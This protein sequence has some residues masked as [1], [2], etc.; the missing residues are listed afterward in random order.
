MTEKKHW[1]ITL[2]E[3]P[4]TGDLIMP[5]PTEALNQ[6]GWDFGDTLVWEDLQNGSWSLK[7]KD[8]NGSDSV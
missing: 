1:T 4:V 7:K 6:L 3:D 8:D 5:L 2:E